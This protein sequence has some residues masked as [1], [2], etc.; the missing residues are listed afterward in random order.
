VKYIDVQTLVVDELVAEEFLMV[1][2][3]FSEQ[4]EIQLQIQMQEQNQLEVLIHLIEMVELH[5]IFLD[6]SDLPSSA[7]LL[8]HLLGD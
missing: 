7:I 2:N 8:H 3:Q 1:L 4:Q 6:V 5:L